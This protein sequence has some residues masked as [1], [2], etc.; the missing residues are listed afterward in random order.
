[1][2]SAKHSETRRPSSERPTRSGVE[3]TTDQ[4]AGNSLFS[5]GKWLQVS[6]SAEDLAKRPGGAVGLLEYDF[7]RS[8]PGRFEV[9]NRV[10]VEFVR[11]PF[12]WRIDSS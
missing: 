4:W 9:W 2:C 5:E 8:Q 10:G 12:A 6:L 1:M 11:S 3:Y 7:S